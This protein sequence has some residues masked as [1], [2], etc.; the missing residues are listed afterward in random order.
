LPT[1]IH[2]A[3][4]TIDMLAWT[5]GFDV[6]Y[7]HT[8]QPLPV[9]PAQTSRIVWSAAQHMPTHMTQ[10]EDFIYRARLNHATI[11]C[12]ETTFLPDFLL[13]LDPNVFGRVHVAGVTQK[14]VH[15]FA[16]ELHATAVAPYCWLEAPNVRGWFSDNGFTMTRPTHTIDYNAWSGDEP[17]SLQQFT[18]ALTVRTLADVYAC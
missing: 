5:A 15:T 12:A 1:P 14:N 11:A 17:V 8:T 7:T 4:L 10:P 16:I 3:T 13:R 6:I 9:V 2:N 18:N